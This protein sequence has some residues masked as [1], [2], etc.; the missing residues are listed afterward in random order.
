MKE[1]LLTVC[2]EC[3]GNS[4]V[5]WCNLC[6]G[7]GEILTQEG[8]ELLNFMKKYFVSRCELDIK[9]DETRKGYRV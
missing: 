1:R 9:L 3:E 5:K 4:K 6:E 7:S 2:T 8:Q